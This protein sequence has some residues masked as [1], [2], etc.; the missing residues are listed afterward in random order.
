MRIELAHLLT[1]ASRATGTAVVIDVFR[2]CTTACFAFASGAKTI[3]P[4]A[5]LEEAYALHKV[6]PDAVLVGERDTIPPEGFHYG[7]SPASMEEA[8]LDG[9]IVIHA[10]S[11]GTPGIVAALKTADEVITGAFANASAVGGYIRE[12]HPETCVMVS[13]G[14]K[15]ET[16]SSEDDLCG[17]YLKNLIEGFPNSIKA[18][19]RH[20]QSSEPAHKFFDPDR[21]HAPERD[22]DLCLSVDLFNFVLKAE[23]NRHGVVLKRIDMPDAIVRTEIPDAMDAAQTAEEPA[24]IAYAHSATPH[25]EI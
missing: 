25:T 23:N 24:A 19:R 14:S 3:Y 22:F 4:V 8:D 20:L 7:N 15:G 18:I 9:K 13:M 1:G 5:T 2:A 10:T 12:R 16:R 21:V 11:A 17:I 6:F